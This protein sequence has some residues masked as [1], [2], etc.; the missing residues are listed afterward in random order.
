MI[1][2][3]IVDDSLL[4]R[5]RI[6]RILEESGR[7]NVA[8]SVSNGEEALKKLNEVEP[9]VITLDVEMP[10]LNGIET[11][12]ILSRDYSI[13]VIMLSA[14][15]KEGA[16]VT[17]EALQLGAM[18]FILKPKAGDSRTKE[19]FARD[20][21]LKIRAAALVKKGKTQGLFRKTQ[22]IRSA[23]R[24][25]NT[26]REHQRSFVNPAVVIGISTGGPR[27]L[28][29][30]IPKIPADFPAPIFIAQHMPAGFTKSLAERLDSASKIKVKE[31]RSGEMVKPSICYIAPGD[32]HMR[33]VP[34][35]LS[36]GVMIKISDQPADS[37]Y[38][39]SVDILMESAAEV[40]GKNA[41]GV[42]MT[43]MGTDGTKGI[44]KIRK[45]GGKT[46]AEDVSSCVVY[47]MPRSVVEAGLADIVAPA[48]ELH[49]TLITLLGRA[50]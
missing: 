13:P 19:D 10:R 44:E 3:M 25:T 8:A 5:K 38:K 33:V 20:L 37:L 45:A 9:D 27:T 2:V 12:K 16:D 4:I 17:I 49:Q 7:V 43:G 50:G 48:G 18:D 36:K 1:S 39:P 47:G 34:M 15:T 46:I 30:V 21:V 26:L 42:V 41:L 32:F 24:K 29:D 35:T 23:P 14:L 22:S 11:L 28:M 40:Y 6:A 31:A